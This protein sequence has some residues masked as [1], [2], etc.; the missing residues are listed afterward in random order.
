MVIRLKEI[1]IREFDIAGSVGDGGLNEADDLYAVKKLLNGIPATRGGAYDSLD[2]EDTSTSGAEWDRTVE[3]I[4]VFQKENPRCKGMFKPDGL[5][6]PDKR[7]IRALRAEYYG[8]NPKPDVGRILTVKPV[9]HQK[10]FSDERLKHLDTC[11]PA[12][13]DECSFWMLDLDNPVCQMVPT[14]GRR[15]LFLLPGARNVDIGV[16]GGDTN[17]AT[18]EVT[19]HEGYTLLAITGVKAGETTLTVSA[20]RQPVETIRVIVRDARRVVV[21]FHALGDPVRQKG[22]KVFGDAAMSDMLTGLNKVY[23]PQTNITFTRGVARV[24]SKI[25]NRDIDFDKTILIDRSN[26]V[27]GQPGQQVFQAKEFDGA[28]LNPVSE[29]NVFMAADMRFLNLDGQVNKRR[30]GTAQQIGVLRAWFNFVAMT[31]YGNRFVLAGHEIGHALGMTHIK[32]LPKALMYPENQANNVF[33]PSEALD[34][35]P[36]GTVIGPP[37]PPPGPH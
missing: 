31:S 5:V 30:I 29:L 20:N 37:P 25:N 18:I 17:F 34:E 36:Q 6:E 26:M 7:T 21:N 8:N 4:Q 9:E 28:C 3:A 35:L 12:I 13:D 10:G 24:L 19:D 2:P 15:D 1:V 23:E 11:D 16:G 32:F 27:R 33:I 22:I 14:G